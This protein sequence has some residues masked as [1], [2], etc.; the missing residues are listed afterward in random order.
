VIRASMGTTTPPVASR[1][2][3]SSARHAV[4]IATR[5]LPD[6]RLPVLPIAFGPVRSRRLGWSLGI[7]NVPPKTCTYSCVYCQVG[8]T[9]RARLE[10]EAYFDTDVVVAAVRERLAEC[11]AA[12]QPIDYATFV[13]DG[14]PT[15]DLH[16]G[17]EIRGVAALGLK[18]AVLTN[19]SLLWRDDV[20]S[21]LVAA[22]W[23]SVKVDSVDEASWREVNRPIGN[24]RL[25]TIIDGM[26]SFA[27]EYHGDLVTETMLVAG[28]NDDA[29]AV[30]RTASFVSSLEP[31]RAYISIP[32]RPPAEPWVRPPAEDVASRAADI[33]RT[34]DIPT[35]SLVEEIDESEAP[36]AVAG[37]PA[38]GLLGIVAVHPMT[39]SAARDYLARAGA[40][41]SLARRLLDD[42]LIQTVRHGGAT[43]L[44]GALKRPG[45]MARSGRR[46]SRV[47]RRAEVKDSIDA[48]NHV[49][50]GLRIGI[51]GKGGSG[52]STLVAL[53]A[54]TLVRHG[55]DVVVLDAD[56]TNVGLHR[57][58]GIDDPPRPLLE[59]F[60][61]S[62]FSGGAV[63]CPVD[64]PTAL[65]SATVD[66]SDLA[67]RY[68]RRSPDGTWLLVAGKLAELGAGA[69]CDGPIAKITRDLEIRPLSSR[70][71]MLVD[72]KAG[73]E[74]SARGVLVRL[75]GAIV[76][77]DPT[78]V[79][80]RMAVAL[81]H[82]VDRIH[83]GALPATRHLADPD[84]VAVANRLYSRARIRDVFVV[85]NKIADEDTEAML[86]R[87]L[88]AESVG[89]TGVVHE[90]P[91]LTRA[92][93]LGEV[94]DG[95]P[96]EG[97]LD[98]IVGAME[99][100]VKSEQGSQARPAGQPASDG[101]SMT[102]R[103]RRHELGPGGYCVCPRC[104]TRVP[105]RRGVRCEEER[106]PKCTGKM[107]REGSDHH[108]LWLTKHRPEQA[109]S[110]R[111]EATT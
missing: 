108:Q 74:D 55:Y 57:A 86:R 15:L 101:E 91:G 44:R 32:T 56:S 33:F 49:L 75:D 94:L 80:V 72:L 65:P 76:V 25:A 107:L 109:R 78:I 47:A 64:D 79:A 97:D 45:S 26:R 59:Y 96:I 111:T 99:A 17:D 69:G 63:T 106:C 16:L 31:S 18:V 89:V 41:W 53:L 11:R 12:G 77:V 66:L 28:L 83:E 95:R 30:E 50:G 110:P 6:R 82:L 27:V 36:F 92:W 40:D 61:G 38:Q 84:L 24:L 13:P 67:D 34:Y 88:A 58:L 70:Q 98:R 85:V 20:R 29:A 42:G 1:V 105:H 23:V 3:R 5:E 10:R 22:D 90:D 2:R 14:E 54:R 39:E 52:K 19:G 37:D 4:A 46:P 7:N 104:E 60:G 8:A 62:V 103:E 68:T 35:S 87:A 73:F 93:L 100:V 48:G 43:Y 71:V 102:G 21:A 9:D 81:T 51:L